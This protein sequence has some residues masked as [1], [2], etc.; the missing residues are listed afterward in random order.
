MCFVFES[1]RSPRSRGALGVPQEKLERSP[2]THLQEIFMNRIT[3]SLTG[4]ALLLLLSAGLYA[5][6]KDCC[7]G[8]ACCNSGQSCCRRAKAK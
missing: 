4:F 8:S 2:T 5:Q 6:V 1:Q 7:N 3:S